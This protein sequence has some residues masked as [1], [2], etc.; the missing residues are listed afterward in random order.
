M[1]HPAGLNVKPHH[2]SSV[3][4]VVLNLIFVPTV[5]EPS[6]KGTGVQSLEPFTVFPVLSVH[7]TSTVVINALFQ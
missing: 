7:P 5:S 6:H 4:T 3:K 1:V 2:I